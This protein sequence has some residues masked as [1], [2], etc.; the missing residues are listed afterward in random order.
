M[1]RRNV[2]ALGWRGFGLRVG[3]G[4]RGIRF[5]VGPGSAVGSPHALYTHTLAFFR[6][7]PTRQALSMRALL[8]ASALVE[9]SERGLSAHKNKTHQTI[10]ITHR[11]I[12]HTRTHTH[13]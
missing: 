2:F 10:F 12:L 7:S 4:R 11:Y 6:S 1:R 9:E 3:L 8:A 5:Y 13:H